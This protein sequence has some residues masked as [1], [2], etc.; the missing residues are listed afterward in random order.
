MNRHEC[1]VEYK[2]IDHVPPEA[3]NFL[4]N[5]LENKKTRIPIFPSHIYITSAVL[6]VEKDMNYKGMNLYT[7]AIHVYKEESM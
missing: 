4:E 6:I 5:F 2:K 3:K 1:S 7:N